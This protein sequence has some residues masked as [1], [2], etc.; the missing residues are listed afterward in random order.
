MPSP[1][2]AA[3]T[4]LLLSALALGG[5]VPAIGAAQDIDGEQ[6]AQVTI[7]ERI[8]IRVPNVPMRAGGPQRAL[9]VPPPPRWAE[10]KGPKCIAADQLAGAIV[11]DDSVDLIVRGGKRLR[12]RLD[13][14]CPALDF[15]SGF[16]LKPSTDGMVCAHRDVI[17]SRSGGSCAI[18]GFRTLV[19][20]R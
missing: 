1:R 17:R 4:I 12:A 10:K 20:R 2:P 16:Y 18:S 13:G 9:P 6:L 3:P 7:R 15:Y 8:I 19:P 14:D 11:G 5:S